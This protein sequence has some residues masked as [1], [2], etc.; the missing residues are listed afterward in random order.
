MA[1]GL[2]ALPGL[3]EG[4]FAVPAAGAAAA[5][6]ATT[7]AGATTAGAAA[8]E[9][10]TV[11]GTALGGAS[12]AATTAAVAGGA[13]AGA[14]AGMAAEGAFGPTQLTGNYGPPAPAQPAT[15]P[16]Q[17]A[18]PAP[19][20]MTS[21]MKTV[22]EATTAAAGASSLYQLAT[23]AGRVQIPPMPM[24]A[25]AQVDQSVQA[26]EQQA[27]QRR[28]AAGGLQST[29]GTGAGQAGAVLNPATLSRGNIL[30]G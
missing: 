15:P 4:M 18:P 23:G 20:R 7:V 2:A 9:G 29:I 30:G 17:T 16:G 24:T 21:I 25:P 3:I 28:A 8:A 5:G 6:T 22:A 14:G 26:A 13:A 10:V 27:L 19:G 12:T 11:A 1:A